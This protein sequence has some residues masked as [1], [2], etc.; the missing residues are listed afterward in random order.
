MQKR[1]TFFANYAFQISSA[2]IILPRTGRDGATLF[3]FSAVKSY[4]DVAKLT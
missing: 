1:E 2:G 4:G 3:A